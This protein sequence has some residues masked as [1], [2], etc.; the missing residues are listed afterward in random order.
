MYFCNL[1]DYGCKSRENALGCI[2]WIEH[3]HPSTKAI[4]V[5]I[6]LDTKGIKRKMKDF[7]WWMK[8]EEHKTTGKKKEK[9]RYNSKAIS[10]LIV[11]SLTPSTLVGHTEEPSLPLS[12]R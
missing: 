1:V 3:P 2:R 5:G 10:T 8:K 11:L 9:G 7:A 4:T 12:V 6:P